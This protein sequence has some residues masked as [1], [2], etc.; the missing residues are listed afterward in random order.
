MPQRFSGR[1]YPLRSRAASS[2]ASFDASPVAACTALSVSP[3]YYSPLVTAST[4]RQNQAGEDAEEEEE[5][6]VVGGGDGGVL[7]GSTTSDVRVGLRV[8]N[9]HVA[10][11]PVRR[12]LSDGVTTTTTGTTTSVVGSWSRCLGSVRTARPCWNG[13]SNGSELYISTGNSD[14]RCGVLLCLRR[15]CQLCLLRRRLRRCLL[16]RLPSHVRHDLLLQHTY[17]VPNRRV[18][19]DRSC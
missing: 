9:G 12:S 11:G 15:R 7:V 3:S 19:V 4:D 18:V 6:A 16:R 8:H 2:V 13:S 17:H 14:I 1:S 10:V 5:R